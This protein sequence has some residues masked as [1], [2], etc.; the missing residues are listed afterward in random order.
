MNQEKIVKKHHADTI[1]EA[2]EGLSFKHPPRNID[3]SHHFEPVKEILV[4]LEHLYF[5]TMAEKFKDSI[6][7]DRTRDIVKDL[8]ELYYINT[9]GRARKT[10]DN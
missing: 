3:S 9:Y 2:I 7:A 6:L 1:D 4:T 10:K 5:Y 8:W